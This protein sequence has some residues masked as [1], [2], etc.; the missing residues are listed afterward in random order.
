MKN[1][2]IQISSTIKV[3]LLYP[4]KLKKRIAKLKIKEQN[5]VKK[6]EK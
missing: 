2:F 5:K 4:K 1:I 3:D 6:P